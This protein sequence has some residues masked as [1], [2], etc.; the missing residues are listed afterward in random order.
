MRM[1]R[2]PTGTGLLPLDDV[3]DRERSDGGPERVIR[4][5]HPVVAM[6]VP[7]RWGHKIG[8]PVQELSHGWSR[9]PLLRYRDAAAGRSAHGRRGHRVSH[10]KPTPSARRPSGVSPLRAA[11]P[12]EDAAPQGRLREPRELAPAARSRRAARAGIR[13]GPTPRLSRV[14]SAL[15]RLRPRSLHGLRPGIRRGLLLQVPRGVCPS[16]NG[17]HMAQTAAHLVDHVIPPVPVRQWVISVARRTARDRY[18]QHLIGAG[19]EVK[20]KPP[21]GQN[22]RDSAPTAEKCDSRGEGSRSGSS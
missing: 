17:R 1:A 4:G 20:L 21:G 9:L 5:E 14:R 15:L 3:P 7:R 2:M 12:R 6:P 8:Q 13:R 19:R 22:R 11:S 10:A 18:P 16:C